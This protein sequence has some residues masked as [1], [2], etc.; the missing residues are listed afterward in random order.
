MLD[1]L[2]ETLL[3]D[4]SKLEALANTDDTEAEDAAASID[5]DVI[6]DVISVASIA[7]DIVYRGGL[8]PAAVGKPNQAGSYR[9]R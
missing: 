1:A 5:V 7:V 6:V 4:A 8:R 3:A 2:A 9:P